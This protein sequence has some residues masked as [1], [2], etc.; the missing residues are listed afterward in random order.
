MRHSGAL[1]LDHVMALMRLFW[2]GPDGGTYVDY[3][4]EDLLA[5]WR[6]KASATS[7]W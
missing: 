7:A 1:R 3:P 4:L 5:C 2:T 6:W